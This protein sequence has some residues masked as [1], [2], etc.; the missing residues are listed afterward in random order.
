MDEQEK[1]LQK[2]IAI[3]TISENKTTIDE[4]LVCVATYLLYDFEKCKDLKFEVYKEDLRHLW[5]Y[6][7]DCSAPKQLIHR[8]NLYT[9]LFKSELI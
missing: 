5:L 8:L 9:N 4:Y 7:R 6:L 2:N 1:L 3:T